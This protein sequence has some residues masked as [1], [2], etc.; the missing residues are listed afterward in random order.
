[1]AAVSDTQIQQWQQQIAKGDEN[2][3]NSLFRHFYTYLVHFSADIVHAKDPAEEIV[4]DVFVKIW[5]QR[6]DI[7]R[8]EKLRIFLFIAVKNRSFNYLRN[9]PSART[10]ELTQVHAAGALHDTG[11]EEEMIFAELQA[12]LNQAI[13]E[14]PDQCRRIFKLIK[15][16]RLKYKEVAEI[17]QIS[18][19]TV[20]T[21]LYR[22]I[23]KIRK[24]VFPETPDNTGNPDVERLFNIIV[25][26]YI[27]TF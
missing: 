23:K 3:F 12:L 2:A 27:L 4:S 16:D 1:M 5:Q 10:V 8:I 11:P 7:T 19:R 21:Q 20:E 6:H 24:K 9:Y 25:I 18:P 14:L 15:E 26:Y 22:A 17:L 13:E